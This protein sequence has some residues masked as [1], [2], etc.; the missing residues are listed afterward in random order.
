MTSWLEAMVAGEGQTV[1]DLMATDDKPISS[2]PGAADACGSTITPMLAQIR[3][4]G[5]VFTGLTI[6]GATIKGNTA[7]FEGV[8]TNPAIAADVVSSFKA[9]RIGGKW[10]VSQG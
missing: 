4:L 9:V 3:Q 10:Y 1:C 2:V 6:S 7:T 5:S 8:T